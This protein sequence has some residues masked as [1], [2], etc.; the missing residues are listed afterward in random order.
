MNTA[1]FLGFLA[2]TL[3]IAVSPGP[4]VALASS[5]AVRHGPKA[6]FIATLGDA[7][8]TVVHILVAVL[9]LEVLVRLASSIL[10]WLQIL[11]GLYIL[12]LAARSL[13]DAKANTPEK[14]KA[15]A[16]RSAFLSG[17]LACVSNPKAIV[18]FMAL[19]P[20]F[21]DTTLSVAVQSVIYGTTFVLID[22]AFIFGYALIAHSA[23][24][25]R[26]GARL[27][28]DTLSGFGLIAVALLLVG[29]GILTL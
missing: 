12:W 28:M 15:P 24:K 18:F 25:S 16:Y 17:F 8:G 22:G 10:P 3:L 11:G 13:R 2:A 29:R 4:S 7:L 21:I 1:L 27:N 9:S 5:Q 19:F 20:G 6:A 14:P 23:A 26:L